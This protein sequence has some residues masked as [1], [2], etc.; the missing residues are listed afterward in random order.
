M[1]SGAV[2]PLTPRS[3]SSPPSPGTGSRGGGGGRSVSRS[4]ACVFISHKDKSKKS[5]KLRQ[6]IGNTGLVEKD[7]LANSGASKVYNLLTRMSGYVNGF[8]Q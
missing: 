6:E 4:A 5:A 8:F 7:H 3:P 1:C 2:S